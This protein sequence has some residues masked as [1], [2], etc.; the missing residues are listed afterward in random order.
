M[1]NYKRVILKLSG[2]ALKDGDLILS[3]KVLADILNQLKILVNEYK[4]EIAI[5]VG[6]GNIWRGENIKELKMNREKADYMGMLAT[7]INA[8]GITSYFNQNNLKTKMQNALDFEKIS[9][10]IDIKKANSY[11]K[12]NY[13]LLF[14]GGTGKPF[15]STDTAA[16]LRALDIQA[17][18]ILMAKNEIDGVYDS[19]PKTNSKAKLFSKLTFQEVID[20]KLKFADEEA[21]KLLQ[22]KNIDIIVFNMNKK[23]NIVNLYN[24]PKTKKTLIYN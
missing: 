24:N 12:N 17:D 10:V 9:E 13:I 20:K 4:I 23:N 8:L 11:L 16:A 7:S 21:M 1:K 22:G 19:D 14:G 3:K 18:A 15:L 6:G 5:V 2:E